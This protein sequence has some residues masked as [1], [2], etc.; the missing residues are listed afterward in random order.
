MELKKYPKVFFLSGDKKERIRDVNEILVFSREEKNEVVKRYNT[1][2]INDIFI[3]RNKFH[4]YNYL[5]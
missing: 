4:G 5:K 3:E 1:S 2:Y